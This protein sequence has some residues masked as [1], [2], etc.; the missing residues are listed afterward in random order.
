MINFGDGGHRAFAPPPTGPLL[1]G[2]RG[3]HAENIVDIRPRGW[4]HELARV[5][6]E[7]FQITALPLGEQNVERHRAFAAAAHPGNH[8]K[9]IVG[10]PDVDPFQI[11]FPGIVDGD[12][13]G[14]ETLSAHLGRRIVSS[15]AAPAA[16]GHPVSGCIFPHTCRLPGSMMYHPVGPQSPP[17]VAGGFGLHL[18]GRTATHDSPPRVPA[19]G[20]KID[21]PVGGPDHV[22][23]VFDDD[24]RMSLLDQIPQRPQQNLDVAEMQP[25]R[26]FIQQKQPHSLAAG[27]IAPGQMP[28][29]FQTLGLS[30]AE[31]GHRLPQRDIAQP[32]C[33]QRLQPAQNIRVVG[34]V[35]TGFGNRHGQ[36][37]GNGFAI[38]ERDLEDIGN[39]AFA[40]A[41]RTPQIHIAEKLHFHMR[42]SIAPAGGTTPHSGVEAERPGGEAPAPGRFR[43]AENLAYGCPNSHI[44]DRVR[45]GGSADRRLVHQ[46][47]EINRLVPFDPPV[48]TGSLQ[49]NSLELPQRMVQHILHQGGFAG[50]AHSGDTNE[51]PQ[52]NPY[53]NVVQ[54][55]LLRPANHQ[56]GASGNDPPTMPVDAGTQPPAQIA[57]RN[58]CVARLQPRQRPLVDNVPSPLSRSGTE[59]D[60]MVG[61]PNHL[62]I[63]LDQK[64]RIAR[65]P[66]SMQDPD[67]PADIPRMQTDAGFVQHKQGVDQRGAQ[68]RSQID[69][70]HFAAA[71]GT[72]LTVQRQISQANLRQKT[73]TRPNPLQY[74]HRRFVRSRGQF[75]GVEKTLA[76]G[77]RKLQ[78]LVQR[79]PGIVAHAPEQGLGFQTGT[80]TCRTK[81]IRAIARKQHPY[82]HPI[83]PGFQPG[84]KTLDPIP[85]PLFPGS[86][87]LHDPMALRRTQLAPGNRHPDTATCGQAQQ[88]LL[89]F[90]IALRLPRLD[91]TL[92]Q[93]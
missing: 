92:L 82:M 5:R 61:R 32:H 42:E 79:Q 68:G 91:G 76:F 13:P 8:G 23:I 89:A 69:T 84:K 52:G 14:G 55:V 19:F 27:E 12:R 49:R 77:N 88:I 18:R 11:V 34:K 46:F 78:H 35:R 40:V 38:I 54:I 28:R 17:R 48:S 1:D 47:D 39:I 59:I 22:E 10:N 63:M 29:Q 3:R 72:G 26:R 43:T 66:Q 25:G 86:L 75:Q 57:P 87:A 21:N 56:G 16:A 74:G 93:R 64:Q 51:P 44:A 71:Q 90:P 70:L 31:R 37:I 9:T 33:G 20:T 2:H 85:H 6:I 80:V 73:Q 7:R 58:R 4:L 53:I 81:L 83:G 45:A 24:N 67:E 60:D 62:G 41:G 65:V 36:D 15:R 50:T 30:P